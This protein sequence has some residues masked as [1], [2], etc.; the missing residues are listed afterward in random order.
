MEPFEAGSSRVTLSVA[1]P[2]VISFRV[3]SGKLVYMD[4]EAY[5]GPCTV[6]PDIEAQ[7]L[8]TAGKVVKEDILVEEIP[9]Y[10][11]SNQQ[12]GTT[13]IIGGIKYGI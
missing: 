4:R 8:P 10:E 1:N 3:E 5:E 13:A 9:V 12:N 2:S 7:V 6:T 11:V